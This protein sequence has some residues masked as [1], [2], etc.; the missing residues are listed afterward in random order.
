MTWVSTESVEGS[1][2]AVIVSPHCPL[3]E[4]EEEHHQ[5]PHLHHDCTHSTDRSEPRGELKS[6]IDLSSGIVE[7]DNIPV[8]FPAFW[9]KSTLSG[10]FYSKDILKLNKNIKPKR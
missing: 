6:N 1:D 4:R 2:P 8:H 10:N 3:V 7:H 5:S 9:F